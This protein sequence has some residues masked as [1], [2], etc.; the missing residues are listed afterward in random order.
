ME[1]AASVTVR[2]RL[3]GPLTVFQDGV[4]LDLRSERHRRVL[5]A[6]LLRANTAVSVADLLVAV[7]AY[8]PPDDGP[9]QLRTVVSE[10]RESIDPHRTP[11]TDGE[12]TVQADGRYVLRVERNDLDLNRFEDAVQLARQL[13][14]TGRWDE[15]VR[16]IRSALDL[17]RGV[18]L[19]G[20]DGPTFESARDQLAATHAQL[21]EDLYQSESALGR[22]HVA[23]YAPVVPSPPVVPVRRPTDW[24]QVWRKLGAAAIPVVT[25]GAGSPVL[26]GILAARR[27][28]IRLG[29][30]AA[31]YLAAAV[32]FW[33]TDIGPDTPWANFVAFF[34]VFAMAGASIQAALVVA[35]AP[36]PA[37]QAASAVEQR[38]QDRLR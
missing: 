30:S 27:R 37:Q 5:A 2:Y 13:R 9:Q 23:V 3:L 20:L 12:L 28:S 36:K 33:A 35:N 11:G 21:L 29:V 15:A 17:W 24:G 4:I 32:T 26:F 10:L 31:T 14:A 7:W 34:Q 18:A 19:T 38:P 25:F 1:A 16:E 8:N 6:L 22:R